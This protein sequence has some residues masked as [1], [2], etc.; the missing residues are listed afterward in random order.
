MK[1]PT[2]GYVSVTPE[3][4]DVLNELDAHFSSLEA[5]IKKHVPAGRKQSLAL[6]NLEQAAMWAAKAV[7]K[8]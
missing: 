6:T 8:D 5:R 4:R 1:I 2:F 7:A 3:Q